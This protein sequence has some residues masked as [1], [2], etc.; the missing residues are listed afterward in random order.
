MLATAVGMVHACCVYTYTHIKL[1]LVYV[2][3]ISKLF[4]R[5]SNSTDW[6]GFKHPGLV[7]WGTSTIEPHGVNLMQY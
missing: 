3:Y 6:Q 5:K 1:V 2:C 7:C 4:R